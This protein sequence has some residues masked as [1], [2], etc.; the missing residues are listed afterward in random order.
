[1]LE[2]SQRVGLTLHVDHPIPPAVTVWRKGDERLFAGEF[3]G[4][5]VVHTPLVRRYGAPGEIDRVASFVPMNVDQMFPPPRLKLTFVVP[6][7]PP[8]KQAQI[9][10]HLARLGG[11]RAQ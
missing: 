2:Q 1:V 6:L 4:A 9:I 10:S 8:P 3:G 7:V 11:D 5:L